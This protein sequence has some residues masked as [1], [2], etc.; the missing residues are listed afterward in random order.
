[1]RCQIPTNCGPPRAGTN[2]DWAIGWRAPLAAGRPG[3]VESET[4]QN[5]FI[6]L[7]SGCGERASERALVS[8]AQ[9]GTI[10]DTG[11]RAF[12]WAPPLGLADGRAQAKNK[13]GN[14]SEMQI[15]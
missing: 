6:K 4:G 9:S 5:L 12:T 8:L 7:A 10:E 1:M 2:A 11:T 3:S 15:A 13:H 14:K